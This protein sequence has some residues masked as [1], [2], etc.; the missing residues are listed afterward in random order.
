MVTGGVRVHNAVL[1]VGCVMEVE[2]E[3]VIRVIKEVEICTGSTH[4]MVKNGDGMM[5]SKICSN[6]YNSKG[7]LG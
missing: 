2:D 4:G 7:Y 5:A 1:R 6:G 3:R